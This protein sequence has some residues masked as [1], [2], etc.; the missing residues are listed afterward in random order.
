MKAER[1][2]RL[3]A[4]RL[5]EKIGSNSQITYDEIQLQAIRTAQVTQ[6]D[7]SRPM[8]KKYVNAGRLEKV[9]KVIYRLTE[10]VPDEYALLQALNSKAI[11]SYGTALFLWGMSDQVPHTLDITVPQGTKNDGDS[12]RQ[13][14]SSLSLC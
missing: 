2:I 3:D 5:M 1:G 10:G 7:I 8:L 12:E 13:C 4:D 14:G 9:R 6:A 11:F